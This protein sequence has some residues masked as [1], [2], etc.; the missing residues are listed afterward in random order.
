MAVGFLLHPDEADTVERTMT[1]LKER[2][3][4]TWRVVDSVDDAIEGHPGTELLVTVGGDGTFLLGCRLAAAAGLPVMGV[5]RGR[6]GFL[7]DVD[8]GHAVDAIAQYLGGDRQIEEH[9]L[10]RFG[11]GEA[12]KGGH[13]E[14]HPAVNDV[15]VRALRVAAI[16]LRVMAD[17]ELLGEFDAD[18][19]VVASALGSTGYALSAGGPP[20]D[21]RVEAI[22]I[23]PLAPHAVVSRAVIIPNSVHLRIIVDKGPAFLAADGQ[24]QIVLRDASEVVIEPGLPLQIVRSSLGTS[25]LHRLREKVRYGVPL[26]ESVDGHGNEHRLHMRP[27]EAL[28]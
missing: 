4:E 5:D 11:H 19:L 9:R 18:G 27:D 10:L 25:W 12:G 17:D 20:V 22:V 6:L 16:R 28:P 23:V 2:G 1:G 15:V 14:V 24:H 21:P 3:I 8:L 26:K 7:T 13:M